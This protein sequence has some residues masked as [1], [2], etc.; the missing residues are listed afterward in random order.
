MKQ[1]N[2]KLKSNEAEKKAKL[3]DLMQMNEKRDHSYSDFKGLEDTAK[4]ELQTLHNLRKQFVMDLQAKV[5]KVRTHDGKTIGHFF[6]Y[7][8]IS[9]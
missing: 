6:N 1:E 7:F 8:L 9:L 4:K 5:K 3:Q 2:D